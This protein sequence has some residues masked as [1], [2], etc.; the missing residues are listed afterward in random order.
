MERTSLEVAEED[1][2]ADGDY[3]KKLSPEHMLTAIFVKYFLRDGELSTSDFRNCFTDGARD[4]GIDA[5]DVYEDDAEQHL[6]VVQSKRTADITKEEVI[7]I[8]EKI[9]RT[10]SDCENGGSARYNLRLRRAYESA[11]SRTDTTAPRDILVCTTAEPSE[12]VK[13]EI[14]DSIRT[15]D[16]GEQYGFRL[17]CRRELEDTITNIEKPK[18]FVKQDSVQIDLGSS[19]L[20]YR[21]PG[22]DMAKGMF[23]NVTASSIQRLYSLYNDQGLFAQNLRRFVPNKKVDDGISKTISQDWNSFWL[24]NNGVT[25]ACT[26]FYVDGNKLTFYDFSIINGCQTA[27]KLGKSVLPQEDFLVPLKVIRENNKAE[28]ARFAEAAN[29]QKPIQ[30][31]DLKANAPEQLQLKSRFGK[32]VPPVYLVIKRGSVPFTKAQRRRR[33]LR[34]WQQL[35]NKSYGQL[36]LSF[37]LQKPFLAFSRAGAIFSSPKTYE[38]VF[39]RRIA[40]LGSEIDLLRLHDAF[41]SWREEAFQEGV[42]EFEEAILNLG[43]LSFIANCALIV[44]DVHGSIDLNRMADKEGWRK[45]VAKPTICNPFLVTEGNRDL[46]ESTHVKLGEL[47]RLILES[48][49]S[50]I[51]ESDNVANL[52]KSDDF[53]L[54]KLTH[55]VMSRRK[56]FARFFE[57]AMQAFR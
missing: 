23:A 55:R 16:L 41:L 7:G 47:F 14:H 13:K 35:D 12:R 11:L 33:D 5:I 24:M 10:L 18:E 19:V 45:E 43:R 44:R 26:D 34:E 29:A 30:D 9:V 50:V 51:N 56:A 49:Q 36:V 1:L 32:N 3:F 31:R 15:S 25:I 27:T 28:M 38:S 37:H 54:D 4:G 57:D 53:Y 20:E 6:A 40:K 2:R 17:V 48:H 46:P 22:E 52:Y 39:K 8:F 21:M 42:N